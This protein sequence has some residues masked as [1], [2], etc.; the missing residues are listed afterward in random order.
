MKNKI[1]KLILSGIFITGTSSFIFAQNS[2]DKIS[3]NESES[4]AENS[5]ENSA[6]IPLE[7]EIK[8]EIQNETETEFESEIET[9]SESE[10]S[11]DKQKSIFSLDTGYLFSGLKNNGWGLGLSYE[12]L[13]TSFLSVKGEFSHCTVFPKDYDFVLT[14]VGLSLGA[15][16]Y[17]LDKILG[18][19]F[20][21][22]VGCCTD[23][24]M[25]SVSGI[26]ENDNNKDTLI[27]V[28]N[29][30]GWKFSLMDYAIIDI[31]Y[32]YRLPVCETDISDVSWSLVKDGTEIGVKVKFN[33]KK[34]WNR[35]FAK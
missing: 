28:F 7:S 27:R 21:A 31:F 15:Y 4:V 1:L 29:H 11:T 13:L 18:D 12:Y 16:F 14:T 24:F 30:F 8:A 6:E 5:S 22:G 10:K 9:E 23:F 33:L 32:C 35:F 3:L 2:A 34:I 20:Y 26:T 17:F 25:Y 19:Y